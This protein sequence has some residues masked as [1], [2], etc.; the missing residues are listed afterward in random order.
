MKV[1]YISTFCNNILLNRER[2]MYVEK[3]IV[4]SLLTCLD[5]ICWMAPAVPAYGHLPPSSESWPTV[6]LQPGSA[7]AARTGA[8]QHRLG[9]EKGG[10]GEE[11]RGEGRTYETLF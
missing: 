5:P 7:L 4:T 9:R 2:D 10:G 3:D 11:G 1:Y 6:T 8:M